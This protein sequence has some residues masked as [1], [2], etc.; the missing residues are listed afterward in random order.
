[1]S[2]VLDVQ[3]IYDKISSFRKILYNAST[4]SE[5]LTNLLSSPEFLEISE[6]LRSKNISQMDIDSVEKALSEYKEYLK[7]LPVIRIKLANEKIDTSRIYAWFRQHVVSETDF[8]FDIDIDES[9]LGGIVVYWKGK[10]VDCSLKTLLSDYFGKE[11]NH[12]FG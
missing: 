10:V 1:M 2:N 12:V 6:Y 9:I 7:G 11:D 4:T 3:K 8:S 5:E